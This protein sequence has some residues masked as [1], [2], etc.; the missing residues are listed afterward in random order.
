MRLPLLIILLLLTLIILANSSIYHVYSQ[1]TP[2]CLT[3]VITSNTTLTKSQD[4]CKLIITNKSTLYV[5]N[6]TNL[7]LNV[8][9]ID[10]SSSIIL[11]NSSLNVKESLNIM[12]NS[13][14]ISKKSNLSFLGN[15]SEPFTGKINNSS[16]EILSSN[17]KG[18][19]TFLQ[20]S[21]SKI[22]STG[23]T[24]QGRVIFE[25]SNNS[26][27]YFYDS[28]NFYLNIKDKSNTIIIQQ[29]QFS[30]F[31]DLISSKNVSINLP[32]G[33]FKSLNILSIGINN[34]SINATNVYFSPE[35]YP[36][37]LNLISCENLTISN[38]INLEIWI[39]DEPFIQG[40]Q[41]GYI[42][43]SEIKLT[44]CNVYVN[45]SLITLW[46][47]IFKNLSNANIY[48]SEGFDLI[49]RN[50][51]NLYLF[52]DVIND[53]ISTGKGRIYS[54]NST[55]EGRIL[56]YNDTSLFLRNSYISNYQ[57]IQLYEN[58]T[59]YIA[60][61]SK[62]ESKLIG[63]NG[64]IN[65]KVYGIIN[66][67]SQNPMIYLQFYKLSIKILVPNST[68]IPIAYGSTPVSGLIVNYNATQMPSSYYLFELE[69][70]TSNNVTIKDEIKLYVFSDIGI[71]VPKAPLLNYKIINNS[72]LLTWNETTYNPFVP[73]SGFYLYKGTSPSNMKIIATLP[74]NL[75][76]YLDSNITF[77]R[78]YYYAVVA[79]NVMGNSTFSNV[80]YVYIPSN[81]TVN[82]SGIIGALNKLVQ[83]FLIASVILISS[84]LYIKKYKNKK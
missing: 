14:L 63:S 48:N 23:N 40:L 51:V 39:N 66:V 50:N 53:I 16:M 8:L 75:Q 64:K 70:Y 13:N 67:I 57:N 83:S 10:N 41:N 55:I 30:L 35:G 43:G 2:S 80:I 4:F 21:S 25:T 81:I 60:T 11:L 54:S 73:I 37:I 44:N 69:I 22:Y 77:D 61:I 34:Y 82:N 47:I 68:Y 72:I 62:V 12:N 78:G 38:S 7:N 65:I 3:A 5:A 17:I 79:F 6:N 26:K 32:Q 31:I 49:I 36:N 52:S 29:S 56:L 24:Y 84:S 15:S 1:A 76:N 45:N 9:I 71:P 27:L 42:V 19:E 18:N 28:S 59:I 46:K 20:I 74:Y 33:Y 58:S